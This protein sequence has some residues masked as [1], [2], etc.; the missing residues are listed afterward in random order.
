MSTIQ[1]VIGIYL[2]STLFAVSAFAQATR[3]QPTDAQVQQAVRD[4]FNRIFIQHVGQFLGA[5][6]EIKGD[7]ALDLG[8]APCGASFSDPQSFQMSLPIQFVLNG[9]SDGYTQWYMYGH[10]LKVRLNEASKVCV[11]YTQSNYEFPEICEGANGSAIFN[12][13]KV[14]YKCSGQN[15]STDFRLRGSLNFVKLRD[16]VTPLKFTQ[17]AQQGDNSLSIWRYSYPAAARFTPSSYMAGNAENSRAYASV[18]E[19]GGRT[20]LTVDI[21][22][23]MASNAYVKDPATPHAVYLWMIAYHA[24]GEISADG[25]SVQMTEVKINGIH[26]TRPGYVHTAMDMMYP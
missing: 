20:F 11:Q 10:S 24:K 16:E 22:N 14:Q 9:L 25:S 12:T 3:V 2:L 26:Y 15:Y 7:L 23:P 8:A 6:Y 21:V 1:K 18:S 5:P 17:L 4:D 19:E 13:S